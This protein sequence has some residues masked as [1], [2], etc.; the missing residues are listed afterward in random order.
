[1][2]EIESRYREEMAQHDLYQVRKVLT[3]AIDNYLGVLA[4]VPA[5]LMTEDERVRVAESF[6][7][8]EC[9]CWKSRSD[10]KKIMTVG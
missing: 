10:Y 8:E 4:F 5:T 6:V 9:G 3:R 1:M 7:A 2:P